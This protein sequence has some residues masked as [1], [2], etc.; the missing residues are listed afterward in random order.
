MRFVDLAED[1]H[2]LIFAE[3]LE[4]SPSTL[5]SLVRVSRA[6]NEI[7]TPYLYRKFVIR[8]A[9]RKHALLNSLPPKTRKEQAALN[10]AKH[11]RHLVVED[12]IGHDGLVALLDH[13][14][15]LKRFRSVNKIHDYSCTILMAI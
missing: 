2:H 4:T 14:D 15:N 6:V 3:L 12:D 9:W 5:L 8:E 10:K 11:I 1:I 7:A 13:I